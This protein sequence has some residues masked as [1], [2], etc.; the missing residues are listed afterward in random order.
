MGFLQSSGVRLCAMLRTLNTNSRRA[1]S[2]LYSSPDVTGHSKHVQASF[3]VLS[4]GTTS[5]SIIV[6]PQSGLS[7]AQPA[8][9][10]C[11]A[12]DGTIKCARRVPV[13]SVQHPEIIPS[14][15]ICPI[16][17]SLRV[18]NPRLRYAQTRSESITHKISSATLNE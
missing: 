1:V 9:L 2:G 3:F 12:N 17:Q 13:Y 4:S 15:H 16:A 5:Y 7:P 18:R 8:N 6:L 10:L 11:L 14:Q